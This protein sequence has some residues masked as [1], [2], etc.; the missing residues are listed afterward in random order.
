[1]KKRILIVSNNSFERES[2]AEILRD[3]Y[4]VVLAESGHEAAEKFVATPVS[5]L[6]LQHGT[7]FDGADVFAELVAP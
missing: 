4:Q 7:P 1:M 2:L 6:V 5:A 3:S